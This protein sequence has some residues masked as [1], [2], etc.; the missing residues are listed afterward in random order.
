[1]DGGGAPETV[2]TEQHTVSRCPLSRCVS[3]VVARLADSPTTAVAPA[4][5]RQLVRLDANRPI[6]SAD[7]P[8]LPPPKSALSLI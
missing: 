8:P 7:A 2:V 6:R 3:P 1:M 5:H 4:P